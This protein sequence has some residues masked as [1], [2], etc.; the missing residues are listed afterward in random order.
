M[1]SESRALPTVVRDAAQLGLGVAV[2]RFQ[3]AMVARREAGDR[4][5]SAQLARRAHHLLAHLDDRR[6]ALSER[7]DAAAD[8]RLGRTGAG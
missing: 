4:A 8:D 6:R 7:L 2:L 1:P 5:P 3:K